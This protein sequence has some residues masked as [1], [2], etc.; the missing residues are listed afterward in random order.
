MP[1][2]RPTRL[3]KV[4]PLSGKAGI[5]RESMTVLRVADSVRSESGVFL[6]DD[7]GGDRANRERD[8]Y[9]D[10]SRRCGW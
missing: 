4:R 1:G 6:N 8:V 2:A 3:M 7:T 5:A 10:S 9:A